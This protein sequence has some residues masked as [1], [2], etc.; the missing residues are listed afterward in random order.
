MKIPTKL[1]TPFSYYYSTLNMNEI[2]SIGTTENKAAPAL[3][4]QLFFISFHCFVIKSYFLNFISLTMYILLFL[5]YL[6][7]TNATILHFWG[8]PTS[9][10]ESKSCTL[11]AAA[12]FQGCMDL[13][14]G[15]EWCMMLEIPYFYKCRILS[16]IIFTEISQFPKFHIIRNYSFQNFQVFLK[17]ENFEYFGIFLILELGKRGING[18]LKLSTHENLS[19]GNGTTCIL[20]DIYTISSITQ[21]DLSKGIEIA[22][23][24]DVQNSC[25]VEIVSN[26]YTYTK[27]SNGYTMT[28]SDPL[29]IISSGRVCPDD[30]WKQVPRA[31]GPFCIKV[32]SSNAGVTR[33]NALAVCETYGG[34]L[35]GF[36]TIIDYNYI[37]DT[38]RSLFPTPLDYQYLTVWIS[39]LMKTACQDDTGTVNCAGIKAFGEFPNQNN[40]D[41][42]RFPPGYPNFTK[43]NT[44]YYQRGLQLTWSQQL[45]AYN[46]MVTNAATEYACNGEQKICAF[47]YAC[48][49]LGKV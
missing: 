28:Y 5:C 26:V 16:N 30:T 36:E 14:V 46:G 4:R 33:N 45:T 44:G 3:H 19:Y 25:P 21:S 32:F 40:Q 13:C 11:N 42:Y 2:I 12:D 49:I 27:N 31:V 24:V 23:K 47:S 1:N 39:G 48:G 35:A 8:Y 9:E 10:E 17:H 41:L 20:C 15:M 22:V 43:L 18:F 7:K 38:A 6:V 34:W 37:F 29:W